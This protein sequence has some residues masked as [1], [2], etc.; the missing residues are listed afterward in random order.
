MS[1]CKSLCILA[2]GI[3]MRKTAKIYTDFGLLTAHSKI[4]NDIRN[5]F[6]VLEGK[7]I[8]PKTKKLLVSPFNTRITFAELLNKEI[9]NAEA[10]KDAYVI[11]KM[12]SLQD[13]KMIKLLYKAS[14]KGVKIQ[15]VCRGICCLVPGIEGQ[16]ENIEIVSI[17]DRFLEHARVYIFGNNH[18]EKV[19][20]GSADYMTRN[21]DNRIEV[22]TPILDKEIKE[23]ITKAVRLQLEDQ[24]KA[25]R[26][27]SLQDNQYI[28]SEGKYEDSSQHKIYE[29][30]AQ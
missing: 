3:L 29:M 19:F 27:N 28:N 23:T 24:V 13:E 16:S 18:K 14:C 25:R 8:I 5:V 6:S 30:L 2:L 9:E 7:L 17:V 20:I 21:L 15:I 4:A 11:L 22:I 1:K 10:G 26:I 12:N